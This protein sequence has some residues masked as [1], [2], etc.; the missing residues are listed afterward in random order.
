MTDKPKYTKEELTPGILGTEIR[1]GNWTK[2]NYHLFDG[3]GYCC[4]GV[5]CQLLGAEVGPPNVYAFPEQDHM[6][7]WMYEKAG[8]RT[9]ESIKVLSLRNDNSH[10]WE[11]PEVDPQG[12]LAY[13]DWLETLRIADES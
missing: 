3:S 12:V 4:L 2:A 13:L 10:D 8:D 1:S 11:E 5:A 9:A 6:P 7:D